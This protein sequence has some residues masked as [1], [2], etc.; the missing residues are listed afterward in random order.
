MPTLGKI[1]FIAHSEPAGTNGGVLRGSGTA[2]ANAFY[3]RPLNYVRYADDNF[4]TLSTTGVASHSSSTDPTP[5]VIQLPVGIY[6]VEITSYA[7]IGN[8]VSMSSGWYSETDGRFEYYKGTTDKI[9]GGTAFASATAKSNH[10]SK[11]VGVFEVTGSPKQYSVRQALSNASYVSADQ[12]CG[13]GS[14][15]SEN[16]FCT[17]RLLQIP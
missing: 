10:P 8:G 11:I 12:A 16:V 17:V 2:A 6:R 7:G 15:G 5:G 4:A 3:A 13:I 1:A 9:L 14:A